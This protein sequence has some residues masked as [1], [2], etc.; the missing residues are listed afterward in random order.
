MWKKS[1]N[2]SGV[3]FLSSFLQFMSKLRLI[4]L[5]VIIVIILVYYYTSSSSIES[6]VYKSSTTIYKI[7]KINDRRP[8]YRLA[9]LNGRKPYADGDR[10]QA[11]VVKHLKLMERCSKDPSLIVVDVGAYIGNV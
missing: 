9:T 1:T 6:T 11:T 7:I 5:I 10:A 3:Q 2:S 4:L 8:G